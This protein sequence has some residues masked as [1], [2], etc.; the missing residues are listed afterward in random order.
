MSLE[1]VT[2]ILR[3]HWVM[4]SSY[5]HAQPLSKWELHFK[6]CARARNPVHHGSIERV[7]S[8]E[9]QQRINSYCLEIIKALS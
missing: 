4:F 1:D 3:V 2:R 7:Y 5:F 8:K 6:E 9:Q